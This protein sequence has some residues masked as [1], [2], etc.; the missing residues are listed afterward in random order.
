[1]RLLAFADVQGNPHAARA[2]V[3]A[4]KRLGIEETY[5]LGNAVGA[6]PDPAGTVEILRKA[7][8][9]LVR[10]PRDLAALGKPPRED[11]RE[12]GDANAA[13]LT[14]ADLAWLRS[15]GP[16]RRIGPLLLTSDP[17][18]HA[19]AS[20]VVLHPG[21]RAFVEERNGVTFACAGRADNPSGEAPY[22]VG[23]DGRVTLRHA[24]WTAP[25]RHL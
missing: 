11:L 18:P 16:P 12:E 17:A 20:L 22:L 15:G 13:R 3:D 14:D 10:G 21:P 24:A 23:E 1:M 4:A 8:V 6:G 9:H 19:G 2:L 7:R 25:T 5:A